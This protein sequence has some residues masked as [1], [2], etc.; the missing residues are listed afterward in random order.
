MV[1]TLSEILE[2]CRTGDAAA[3]ATLVG[4]FQ[5]WA[6]D[7]ACALVHD[8]ALAEDV[9]QETFLVALRGL[10]GLREAE[11]FPGWL[12]QILRR[13]AARMS[14]KHG[15]TVSRDPEQG[16]GAGRCPGQSVERD[17]LR[18]IVRN[19]LE[20]LPAAEREAAVRFYIDQQR[21]VEIAQALSIPPSTVRRRLFDARTRL[22]DLLREYV[23]DRPDRRQVEQGPAAVTDFRF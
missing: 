3:A 19:A 2:R 17:E 1:E 21:C 4:R 22:R 16:V 11:A 8:R 10:D 14:R 12:R 9:V 7:L 23:D 13:Q 18:A 5:R 20:R 15:D 6:L